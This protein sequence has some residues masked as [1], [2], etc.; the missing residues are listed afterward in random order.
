MLT[1]EEYILKRKKEDGINEYAFDK[2]VENTRICVN[3]VF[4]FFNNYLE[5]KA[6]D[7]KTILH[8]EKID[9]Y[10]NIIKDY[11]PDIQDWLI[12]LYSSYGKYMHRNLANYIDDTYF[13][14]YDTEAEFRAL[15]YEIYPRV[16]KKFKFLNNQSE[17]IYLFIKDQHRVEN[18][19]SSYDE[20]HIC[21]N[22]DEWITDTYQK[23]G[24]NLFNFGC[25]WV[26][27]FF[28][29][30]DIWPIHHKK[31]SEYYDKYSKRTDLKFSPTMLWNYD[32]TQKSNLF[33]LDSLYRNMPKKKFT[34]SRKQH[35]ELLL[36]Y[37]WLHRIEKDDDYWN[38]YLEKVLP[39]I[40]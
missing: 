12:S 26:D 10:R 19:F 31:K 34:K 15:S 38:N 37:C 30:P 4:E 11:D 8:E 33:N 17:K 5:T 24:V 39:Q 1:L 28:E 2:R 21:E 20:F 27:Y 40:K 13:L 16:I 32:Y 35:F 29:N 36:L 14:L 25:G 6:A 3:Y 7:E 23:Y 18:L 22:V 9:K